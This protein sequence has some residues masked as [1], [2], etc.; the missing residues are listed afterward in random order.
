MMENEATQN[1]EYALAGAILV[2]S[3]CMEAIPE[4][5]SPEHFQAD[6]PRTVFEAAQALKQEGSQVDYVTIMDWASAHNRPLPVQVIA[7]MMDKTPSAAGAGH[8]GKIV[9]ENALRRT[10][11]QVAEQVRSGIS[12]PVEELLS[13]TMDALSNVQ[14]RTQDIS[15]LTAADVKFEQPRW[16]IKPYF[17]RGKGTLIQADP[18]TGKTAFVCAIAAAVSSGQGFLGLKVET[19]G[20]VL[21]ISTEDENSILRG[22]IEACGGDLGKVYF[23]QN[24]A[25][26]TFRS[27]EIE[28]AIV[29]LQAKLVIF[30]PFQAFL[31]AKVDLFRANETRPVM[32]ALFDMCA[33]HDCACA[34]IAHLGKH[35]IGK[36]AVNQSL[37]S[38]DIPGIMR[39]ILHIAKNPNA[40]GERVAVHIKS[41]NAAHGQSIH[42]TIGERGGVQFTALSEMTLDDLS[43]SKEDGF[44]DSFYEEMA[45]IL[46]ELVKQE[47]PANFYSYDEIRATA[48]QVHG[49]VP[50]TTSNVLLV[51][52]KKPEFLRQ[53]QQKDGLS[54]IAPYRLGTK[55][56]IR[57][58]KQKQ[59]EPQTSEQRSQ[60][61]QIPQITANNAQEPCPPLTWWEEMPDV[62][63][64]WEV[65]A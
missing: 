60:I 43:G 14:S 21:M 2:D 29:K 27:P 36:S 42:F 9:L 56:G 53:L 4:K 55:R 26:L 28:S 31:G 33:K 59:M 5:L 39:S 18:G 52:L 1:T 15:L 57:V 61:P 8:Y 41:S 38:V 7:Q 35:T 58:I 64:P 17:Q 20:N 62:E 6:Y 30:D 25:G 24:T 48:N 50:F 12:A 19:P 3:R 65:S 23:M 51:R 11:L 40:E 16:L 54:V 37:G 47:R 10:M 22:R 49:Y 44:D 45:A 63:V 34:I 32:N 46:R 13:S